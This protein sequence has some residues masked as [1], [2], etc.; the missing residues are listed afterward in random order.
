VTLGAEKIDMERSE[1]DGSE[2]PDPQRAKPQRTLDTLDTPDVPSIMAGIRARIRAAAASGAEGSPDF[3][4]GSADAEGRFSRK[5]SEIIHSEELR[6]LNQNYA[7]SS[8]LNAE[9]ITSHRPGVLG[10][11]IVKFKRKLVHV[12]WDSLLR[13][14]FNAEREYQ[15]HLVRFLNDVSSQIGARGSSMFWELVRKIDVDVG[16]TLERIERGNDQQMAELRSTERRLAESTGSSLIEIRDW[17]QRV[18]SMTAQHEDQLKVLDSV[19]RG[20]ESV[21]GRIGAPTREPTSAPEG[22][23]K[24]I[25]D[26]SYLILENRFRGSEAEIA[27]RLKIYPPI[28]AESQPTK[29]VLEI[30]A[31][32]GELQS[33]FREGGVPSFGVDTDAAMVEAACAKGLEVKLMDGLA[34]LREAEDRSLGG[35]IAVQVVEHLTREQQRELFDLCRSKVQPGG[36]V[37]FETINPR[38]LLALSS[39]YFRDPTH[40]WPQHPDTLGFAMSMAGLQV[41]ETRMLSPVAAEAQLRPLEVEEYMTPRWAAMIERLNSNLTQLNDLIYGCQ[42][43]CIVACVP[44][45][46]THG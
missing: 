42:D 6:Y 3:V 27:S 17:I 45:E 25:S 5:P 46:V 28:F 16:K 30:G 40:V 12:I 14:Y 26:P 41:L 4:P 22:D 38:S 8:R 21:V 33:L 18:H 15:S 39:N 29:P 19:A 13:D 36:R 31:G 1:A 43:F 37:I 34:C 23:Q 44:T 20:L 7:Y 9:R 35:V 32:R 2:R 11:M 24:P 10:R